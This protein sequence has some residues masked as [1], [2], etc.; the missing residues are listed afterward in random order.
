[1]TVGPIIRSGACYGRFI[2]RKILIRLCLGWRF[3]SVTG[4]GGVLWLE[5]NRIKQF[6]HDTAPRESAAFGGESAHHLKR[7]DSAARQLLTELAQRLFPQHWGNRRRHHYHCH[8]NFERSQA[9][10]VFLPTTL[11][12]PFV[13]ANGVPKGI[14]Q[15]SLPTWL[16]LWRAWRT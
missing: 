16:P 14:R 15:R 6:V 9:G 8:R 11:R 12:I 5:V 3:L 7:L 1:M 10:N 4:C 13:V 2:H